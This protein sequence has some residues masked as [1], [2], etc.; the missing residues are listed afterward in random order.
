MT[1]RKRAARWVGIPCAILF[2][3]VPFISATASTPVPALS[4]E[5]KV[6][7]I[8]I[9]TAAALGELE[10]PGVVFYH[11]KH[12]A[13]LEKMAKDCTSCHMENEGKLSFKFARLKDPQ[14]VGATAEL[15]HSSCVACHEK[16]VA[17]YPNAPKAAE[18]KRCHVGPAQEG[19]TATPKPSLDLN[20]HGR[21]V[22]AEAKLLQIPQEESCKAC[23]H[24]FDDAQKKLVYAK[25]EE[26]NCVYCHKQEPIEVSGRMAPSTRDAS[27]ESCVNCHLTTRKSQ[28][29]SGPVLCAD[30]HT[31]E[32]QA[33]WKKTPETPR[34]M[35]GQSDAILLAA[36]TATA[37]GTLDVNWASAGPGP[38]AFDH[39]AHEGFVG[40]CVTCHHPTDTG[41]SLAACGVACHTTT[42]SKD[43]SFVTTAQAS[44]QL[45]VTSSCVGCHTTQANTRKECAGCHAPMKQTELSQKSCVQCHEAGFPTSGTQQLDK[46]EREATAAKILAAKDQAPKTVPLENVPEKLTLN[47]LNGPD[48]EWQAAEFP[49]RKIYQKLVEEAAKSPM[50]AHFHA[51]ALTMCAGC[52]HNAQ[53]SLNPPKCAS[54]HSKPF[55]ERTANQP[56]LKGAFHNQCIGCH[57]EMQVKPKATDCQ[58]CHKPKNS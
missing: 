52:H 9:D 7:A 44:H 30:C 20:L 18:C 16:V 54:C 14:S 42:G 56:G 33:K 39:K 15:Y 37:N 11:T 4:A 22:T 35:R 43:G 24:K 3:T 12:T 53:P 21:H 32:A 57:Q 36:G 55:Q 26:G 6:D 17:N 50:A 5:P 13:A 29:E 51:D 1:Q 28:P 8:V 19:A 25:G 58:G 23:H 45:G 48:D 40:N 38:V 49:H 46:Q 41:G 10:Q 47:Y 34:L 31:A 2:L 27:H